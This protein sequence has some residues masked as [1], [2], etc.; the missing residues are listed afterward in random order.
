QL[1]ELQTQEDLFVIVTSDHGEAFR[2]HGLLFH[3]RTLY[4]EEIR[5]PLFI[6]GP[7][8]P[9]TDVLTPVGLIDLA[10]TIRSLV[11][12]PVQSTDGIDLTH[13]AHDR[14]KHRASPL[15]SELLPYPRYNQHRLATISRDGR[16]KLIR[17]LTRHTIEMFDLSRD[18]REKNNRFSAS[19][20]TGQRL[21]NELE[22][23]VDGRTTRPGNTRTVDQSD[24][25]APVRLRQAV[26]RKSDHSTL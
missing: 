1:T 19:H 12:L 7:S 9:A 10:P 18:P 6:R 20:P 21:K 24:H 25:R 26:E 11:G 3:G 4:N 5:V 17:N 2:E 15:Y 16:W 13:L 23:F 8:L 22:R 14:E